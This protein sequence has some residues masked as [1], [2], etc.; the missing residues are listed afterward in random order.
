M[1]ATL[2]IMAV[3]RLTHELD[4]RRNQCDNGE[5]MIC[6]NLDQSINHYVALSRE[7]RGYINQ[8]AK[9]IFTGQAELDPAAEVLLK[10]EVRR[11]LNRAKQVAALGRAMD[12]QCFMLQGLNPLHFHIADFDYLLE[13]WVSPQLAVSPAPR[14]KL[15]YT[16]ESQ[17][18][19]RIGKLAS[20]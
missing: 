15:S 14:V 2:D 10:E 17:I 6:A 12:E 19:E 11:H 16:A 18:A 9:S 5:G 13:N 8:W 7:L 3:R 1:P 4:A 20:S